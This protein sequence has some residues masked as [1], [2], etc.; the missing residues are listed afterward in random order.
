MKRIITIFIIVVAILI[1]AVLAVPV[2]L[3]KPL[4]E[5]T[6]STINKHINAE[7]NFSGFSISLLRSF[8]KATLLLTDVTVIGSGEFQNDTLLKI[9]EFRTRIGLESLLNSKGITIEEIILNNPALNLKVAANGS[10]NW[11]ITKNNAQPG[12]QPTK[13]PE[14]QF[15][16]QLQKIKIADGDISY[17]D[18]SMPMLLTF[19]HSNFDLIGKMFGTNAELEGNGNVGGF[20]LT[21]DSVNY[22]SGSTLKTNSV[23]NVD[24]D[25]MDIFIK[26]SELWI[27]NLPFDL[28]GDIKMPSDTI[29]FNLDFQSKKSGFDD[30]LAL[31][32]PNYNSYLK[33]LETDGT[34]VLLG[35]IKGYYAEA[36]YPVLKFELDIDGGRI[37]YSNLPEEITNIR[38]NLKID[39]PQGGNDLIT[40]NFNQAHAEIKDNPLD[41]S[42]LLSHL[43]TNPTFEG[44]LDAKIN[45][46]HLK[47]ALPLDSIDIAGFMDAQIKIQGDYSQIEKKQYNQVQSNGKILLTNFSFNNPS[48][49]QAIGIPNG[50]IEFTP[51]QI[52]LPELQLIIGK[53]DIKLDGKINNYLNY[54]F[55]NGILA[56]TVNLNSNN[57]NISELMALQ[58]VEQKDSISVTAAKTSEQKVAP[59][60][61]PPNLDF[62]ISATIA[63]LVYDQM[64][65]T[66]IQGNVGLKSGKLNL[67]GLD[68]NL[69]QGK[70][71]LSGFYENKPTSKP[72]FD[73]SC[74]VSNI[75][76]KTAYN[77][78]SMLQEMI[79]ELSQC[80]GQLG[81]T[82]KLKGVFNPELAIESATGNINLAS[83]SYATPQFSKIIHIPSGNLDFT[84]GQ[85]NLTRLSILI[86]GS[87]INL[88]GK[89]SNYLDYYNNKGIITGDIQLKS[90]YMNL[91]ELM[92]LQVKEVN[93]SIPKTKKENPVTAKQSPIKTTSAFNIPAN[94]DINFRTEINKALYGKTTITNINGNTLIRNSKLN[95]QGLTMNMLE[96]EMKLTGSYENTPENKPLFDF[97]FDLLNIDIPIAFNSFS[98]VQN[99]LPIAGHSQGK[100]ISSFKMK[101]QLMPDMKINYS[102]LNGQGLLN[103]LNLQINQ[104]PLFSQLSGILKKEKLKNLKVADFITN[105]TIENGN[106][107]LKPFKTKI[108]GQETTIN[109]RLN[110]QN[111]LD[112]KLNFVIERDAFGQDIQSILGVIP[113]QERI[114]T[115]PA[116]VEIN[117]P[118]G[119][120]EIKIDLSQAKDSIIS[121]LKNTSREDLQ[122][123]LDKLSGGIKKLFK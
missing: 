56:G 100:F 69:L 15:T 81:G 31:I 57:L 114:K 23:V 25:K 83:F 4:L 51:E 1:A 42:L 85:I 41:F 20:S 103:T 21:Y 92:A 75:D 99:R 36:D 48:F 43:I 22:I 19:T 55:Q 44:I 71:K 106:L 102:S 77:S 95:L 67:S 13:T 121:E 59:I 64:P 115:V 11:D 5:K 40:I 34:A 12:S 120:P 46:N 33:G 62:S 110:T 98:G 123:S 47:N 87:D 72:Q 118:I 38:T 14:K 108:A 65:V 60:S 101:G 104:S 29:L 88:A 66:N 35:A 24:Y 105:F 30:F 74:L 70:I 78:V 119:K 73:F 89:I 112:M 63:K 53:S 116:A 113:G 84:S 17:D 28:V 10:T 54:I 58:V 52:N 68:M 7:V 80:I 16:I 111:I 76:V 26:Q 32:P 9:G 8:P 79:P 18:K 90:G 2:I 45:F 39:K 82:I 6:K 117:G 91:N 3:K 37:N 96:G 27:N 97:G 61:L 93:D 109:G 50:K 107:L 86:G 49:T 94:I 122:K